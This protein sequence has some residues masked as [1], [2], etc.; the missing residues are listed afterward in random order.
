MGQYAAGRPW[1]SASLHC[2]ALLCPPL[3]K[4]QRG[5]QY[6]LEHM[7]LLK[8]IGLFGLLTLLSKLYWTKS[9]LRILIKIFCCVLSYLSALPT[10]KT[11]DIF[12]YATHSLRY[13]L[14]YWWHVNVIGIEITEQCFAFL[15]CG[16]H[17]L[18]PCF[19]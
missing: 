13:F 16:N 11:Q 2:Q 6:F 18:P 19:S 8:T 9:S 15:E 17:K 14:S 5:W 3:Q 4:A 10:H 7:G 12:L 1:H